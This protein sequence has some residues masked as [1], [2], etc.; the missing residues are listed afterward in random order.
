MCHKINI[1]SDTVSNRNAD[2]AAQLAAEVPEVTDL[3]LAGDIRGW[4][5]REPE[6]PVDVFEAIIKEKNFLNRLIGLEVPE[7]YMHPYNYA[8]IK[9]ILGNALKSE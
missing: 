8:R 3:S 5:G 7:F 1:N 6:D 2:K 4:G 9:T